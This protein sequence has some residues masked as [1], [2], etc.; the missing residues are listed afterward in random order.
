[1]S[2]YI[3]DN[4]LYIEKVTVSQLGKDFQTPTYIYSQAK[5]K[6]NL[7]EWP[8]NLENH[9]PL[10]CF[11][12][13]ANDNLELLKIIAQSGFGADIVS[14]GELFLAKKAGFSPGKIVFA[15]VGKQAAEI[16]FALRENIK[17]FNIESLQELELIQNLAKQD[18][19]KANIHVRV[20]PDIDAKSHPYISTGLSQNKFGIGLK[21]AIDLAIKA[22]PFSHINVTGIHVH[23]GSQITELSPFADTSR[24]IRDLYLELRNRGIQIT[25]I[26]LGGGLGIDYENPVD[27]SENEKESPNG[28]SPVKYLNAIT[29]HLK[30]LPV[31]F[32]FEPGRSVIANTAILL[33][34]VLFVKK[35]G[36]KKFVV[37]DAGMNDL[38][39]PSLYQAYHKI[40]PISN[41][42]RTKNEV[43]DIVGPICETGDFFAK[44]RS[45]PALEPGEDI[46]IFSVGAYGYS[47]SSNYN[48]RPKPAEI[49]VAGSSYRVIRRAENYNDFLSLYSEIN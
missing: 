7:Q 44:D 20:N 16:Q 31:N 9:K 48:A 18:K 10:Y 36:P 26:D 3:K 22:D 8:S 23:I 2:I 24:S 33:T 13:K 42:N 5:L 41:I 21:D 34:K 14:G 19:K 30:D 49:L 37:V 38:I 43:V 40:L 45:M 17:A 35:N 4:E 32:I 28:L 25:T 6:K 39:R 15:G 46:A 12:F 11:A 1:M 27:N 47:L 29:S